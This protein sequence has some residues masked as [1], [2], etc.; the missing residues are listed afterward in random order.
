MVAQRLFAIFCTGAFATLAG[1]PQHDTANPGSRRRR[2]RSRP[3]PRCSN[4]CAAGTSRCPRTARCL[5]VAV[6][7]FPWQYSRVSVRLRAPIRRCSHRGTRGHG[8][9]PRARPGHQRNHGRGAHHRDVILYD[10]RGIGFSEP[11]FCP[12]VM[13]ERAGTFDSPAA[14]RDHQRQLL[15][16]CGDFMRRAG[17]DLS[18]YNSVVSAHDLQDLRR[19]LRYEQWNLH[20][21]RMERGSRWSRCE[22]H[23]RA[24]AAPCS[25]GRPRQTR[26]N[27]STCLG[28]R[29]RAP[30]AVRRVRPSSGLQCRVSG[31]R[32][33]VLADRRCARARAANLAGNTA[34]RHHSDGHGQGGEVR[35]WRARRHR[36]ATAGGAV[37]RS[38]D[39]GW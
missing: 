10:Q 3:R 30:A 9:E 27:R 16:R 18:Q 8:G 24:F 28:L 13:S 29:R 14:R 17:Y 32:A 21:P 7:G 1:G 4:R 23:L 33:D 37:A 19:A 2:V 12:E 35:C 31:G 36:E 34:K 5:T 22:W 38:R 6:S 26:P 25:T 39:A 15:V 11:A 20:G